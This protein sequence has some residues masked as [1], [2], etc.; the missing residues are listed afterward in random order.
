MAQ[1][2]FSLTKNTRMKQLIFLS[3]IICFGSLHAQTDSVI[4]PLEAETTDTSSINI[5]DSIS[6]TDTIVPGTIKYFYNTEIDSL[7]DF[8]KNVNIKNCPKTVKGF[9]VQIYSCSGINCQEKADK[10]YNQFLIAYPEIPAEKIWDPPSY[11]VRVGNC[12][13][14]FEAEQIKSKI[15]ED[16]PFIFIVP[17]FIDSPYKVDCKNLE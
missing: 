3:L 6:E 10:N 15:K 2:M 12:R 5:A 14:R 11:K 1:L 17:D 16:F 8:Q 4:N 7:I 13:N 9:R